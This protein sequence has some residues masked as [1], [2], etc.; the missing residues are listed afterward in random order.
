MTEQEKDPILVRLCNQLQQLGEGYVA[1]IEVVSKPLDAE[2]AD[3]IIDVFNVPEDQ[4]RD[5]HR[6]A[7]PL[8]RSARKALG[9]AIALVTHTPGATQEHFWHALNKVTAHASKASS[10]W[11]VL[12]GG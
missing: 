9:A 7:Y 10:H 3:L 5:F 11:P 8:M 4:S 12:S 1:G 6:K 2:D